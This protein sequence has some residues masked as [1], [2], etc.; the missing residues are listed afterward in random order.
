MLEDFLEWCMD[1]P[2]PLGFITWATTMMLL[3]IVVITLV[4]S[5]VLFTDGWILLILLGFPI[6]GIYGL[7]K[8]IK[9][10]RK[11]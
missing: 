4:S 3:A 9:E 7:I 1:Q 5:V 8:Y 10:R 2:T 6:L 11:E